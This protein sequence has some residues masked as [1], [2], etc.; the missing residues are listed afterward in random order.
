MFIVGC[1]KT[2]GEGGNSSITG[3]I[4]V[5]MRLILSNPNTIQDTLPAADEDVFIVYGNHVSPDD[6]VATNYDGDFEF[7]NLRSGEY[8][9]YVYSKDTSATGDILENKMPI[10]KKVI[11]EGRKKTEKIENLFI[12]DN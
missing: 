5:E 10:I 1:K 6:K 12:Y 8:T 7:R 2:P 11:I 9:L 3:N 4:K